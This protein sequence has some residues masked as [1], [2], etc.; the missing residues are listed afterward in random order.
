MRALF[1]AFVSTGIIVVHSQNQMMVE[2]VTQQIESL[3]GLIVVFPSFDLN[4]SGI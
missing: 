2:E 3:R 4:E 1:E